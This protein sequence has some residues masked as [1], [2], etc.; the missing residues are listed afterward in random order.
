MAQLSHDHPVG[1]WSGP[2]PGRVRLAMMIH[3]DIRMPEKR[4][5]SVLFS[6]REE[7]ER[8]RVAAEERRRRD[9]IERV[10]RDA[11]EAELARRQAEEARQRAERLRLEEAERVARIDAQAR[12]EEQ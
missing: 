12:L 10:R 11:E 6:L 5:N 3:K 1:I 9:E 4:E 7:E 8:S 2:L